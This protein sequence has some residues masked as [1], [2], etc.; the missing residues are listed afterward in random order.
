MDLTNLLQASL[1]LEKRIAS[2][3]ALRRCF[4]QIWNQKKIDDRPASQS[5]GA[6]RKVIV[7]MPQEVGQLLDATAAKMGRTPG[8]ILEEAFL[9]FYRSRIQNSNRQANET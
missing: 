2:D 6:V 9:L 4:D 3:Q 1:D 7:T 8:E 5:T